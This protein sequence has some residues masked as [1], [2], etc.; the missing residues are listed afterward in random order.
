MKILLDVLRLRYI[1]FCAENR[2]VLVGYKKQED[3]MS[4]KTQMEA[5]RKGIATKEMKI[6]AEKENMEISKLMELIASKK[7][8]ALSSKSLDELQAELASL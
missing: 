3:F 2:G 7:D 1:F 6:V 8:E 5:A 4:Y